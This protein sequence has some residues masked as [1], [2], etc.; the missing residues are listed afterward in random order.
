MLALASRYLSRI[1]AA[2]IMNRRQAII[3]GAGCLTAAGI[4]AAR[5]RVPATPSQ[6]SDKLT[7]QTVNLRDYCAADGQHVDTYDYQALLNRQPS[8]IIYPDNAI[9]TLDRSVRLA[10]NQAHIFGS[11]VRIEANA[12]DYALL[13][14]GLTGQNLGKLVQPITRYAQTIRL[15]AVPDVG[16]GDIIVLT[17]LRDPAAI[18]TDINIVHSIQGSS[19]FTRYPIGRAFVTDQFRIYHVYDPAQ[20]ITF[21]GDLTAIN[22]HPSGGIMRFVYA[23]NVE[24]E[25]ITI[26]DCGY[27]GM[28]FE[29]SIGGKFDKIKIHSS[30]AS[31]LG[32]RTSKLIK[33]NDFIAQGIRSDEAL[34]FYDNVSHAYA[35]KLDIRQYTFKERNKGETAGNNILIDMECSNINIEKVKCVGSST[36]NV[37]IH[38]NCD[39]CS[40]NEFDLRRSNLGGIRISKNSNGNNIGQGLISDVL[41]M[42]DAEANKNVSGISIGK[43]CS[44]TVIS[45]SINF[46]RIAA[47]NRIIRW[48][49]VP[50]R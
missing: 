45:K 15:D 18:R 30:G 21:R 23:S 42:K 29:N 34:T 7:G 43:S 32:F 46:E 24:I 9:L 14:T 40:I 33:V 36:Y 44:G 27:I 35:S 47:G 50:A 22:N 8:T 3:G 20:N 16:P 49:D 17:D 25:G 19:I 2:R 12:K 4:A 1:Q 6:R 41:D 39:N 11:N 48:Q 26:S 37:M 28:S 38:N 10:S 13:A 31:G 5:I